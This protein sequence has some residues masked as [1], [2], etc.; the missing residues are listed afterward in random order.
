MQSVTHAI[1]LPARWEALDGPPGNFV[2]GT[3]SSYS[4]THRDTG[5]TSHRN[6]F[7]KGNW[8]SPQNC[9]EVE[10]GLLESLPV[11]KGFQSMS[12]GGLRKQKREQEIQQS[13]LLWR[14]A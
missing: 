2:S 10:S 8:V 5:V 1:P 4:L 3:A 11:P 13:S 12:T 6:G 14:R 9:E 7:G